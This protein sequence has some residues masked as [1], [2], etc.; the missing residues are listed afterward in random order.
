MAPVYIYHSIVVMF[1]LSNSQPKLGGKRNSKTN[2][3]TKHEPIIVNSKSNPKH[4]IT[5]GEQKILLEHYNVVPKTD[6][7]QIPYRPTTHKMT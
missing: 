7:L 1:R 3:E 5:V 4:K 2:T 6:W